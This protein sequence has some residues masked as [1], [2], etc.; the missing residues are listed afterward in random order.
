MQKHPETS[1]KMWVLGGAATSCLSS[2]FPSCLQSPD[3][4]CHR[5]ESGGGGRTQREVR[6]WTLL[7][8]AIGKRREI[9]QVLLDVGRKERRKRQ[10]EVLLVLPL[11]GVALGKLQSPSG[12][13][14]ATLVATIPMP[15]L[16]TKLEV[17]TCQS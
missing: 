1:K 3:L 2:H 7:N 12:P 5:T 16:L 8:L 17:F 4:D 11:P 6:R 15:V 13:P 14:G 9:R 10:Q